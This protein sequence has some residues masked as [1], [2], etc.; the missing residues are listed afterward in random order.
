MGC[1]FMRVRGSLGGKEFDGTSWG[2]EGADRQA[3]NH[4][5]SLIYEELRRLAS[6]VRR[7]DPNASL[8]P[9]TL[10]NEA[11]LKLAASPGLSWESPMHFK[12]IAARAMRQLLIESARR[13]TARKRGGGELILVAFDEAIGGA[14][15]SRGA[16]GAGE[17]I[18][19]DGA[20]DELG[21]L[22][23]RQAM[24]VETRFFGGLDVAET[25]RL[26]SI[27]EATVMRDWRAAKAWLSREMARTA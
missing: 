1:I 17:L 9:T 19:L 7:S 13:R 18:R 15:V 24:I 2:L 22:S 26:L 23:P 12:R 6:A 3:L 14:A 27:S 25:A 8:S 20:L 10:V 16:C 5:F 4:V 11:W 21:K